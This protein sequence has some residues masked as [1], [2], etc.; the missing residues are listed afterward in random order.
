M[1]QLRDQESHPA[2]A[3]ICRASSTAILPDKGLSRTKAISGWVSGPIRANAHGGRWDRGV[4]VRYATKRGSQWVRSIPNATIASA[5]AG[6]CLV[7]PAGGDGKPTREVCRPESCGASLSP[8]RRDISRPI[9]GYTLR[10]RLGVE[11]PLAIIVC[12]PDPSSGAGR[13]DLHQ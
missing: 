7:E 4:F 9:I 12:G 6:G 13:S 5:T 10:D 1:N 8:V 11:I 3:L 2:A